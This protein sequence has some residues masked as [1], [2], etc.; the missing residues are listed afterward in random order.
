MRSL[1]RIA[2]MLLPSCAETAR[3]GPV[4]SERKTALRRCPVRALSDLVLI[5]R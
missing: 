3:V 1:A 2:I 5:P 4:A